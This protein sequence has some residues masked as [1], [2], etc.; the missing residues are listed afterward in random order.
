MQTWQLQEA[1]SRLS[2]LIRLVASEGPQTIS[3]RG[4]EQVVLLSKQDYDRLIGKELPLSKFMEQSPLKGLDIKIVR[5][6][7]KMR[8]LEL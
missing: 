3:V 7:S 6:K 4:K 8:P 5:D 1:K 2:E